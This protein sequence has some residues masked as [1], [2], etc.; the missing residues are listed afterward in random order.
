MSQGGLVDIMTQTSVKKIWKIRTIKNY[1]EAHNHLCV[2]EVLNIGDSYANKNLLGIPW[3]LAIKLTD[4]QG[5]TLRNSVIWNK[6][7]GGPDNTKDRLRNVHENLFHFVKSSRGY[8]YDV[9]SIRSTPKSS[10]VVNGAI[11]SA[12]GVSGVRYKRQI[13]LSTELSEDEKQN[14]YKALEVMLNAIEAFGTA[15]DKVTADFQGT[16]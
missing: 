3:R 13:E 12:T 2:G 6:I 16:V 9:D 10:K 7:K 14:A 8:Y 5:W 15:D 1:P 11:V 4:E